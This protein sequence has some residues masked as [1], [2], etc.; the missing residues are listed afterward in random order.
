MGKTIVNVSGRVVVALAA[1]AIVVVEAGIATKMI[2]GRPAFQFQV[3]V[4]AGAIIFIESTI[5]AIQTARRPS[6]DRRT[7]RIEKIVLTALLSVS[8]ITQIPVQKLGG[9]VFVVR[10]PWRS[11]FRLQ[12]I[13]VVRYRLSDFPAPSNLQWTEGVGAIGMAVQQKMAAHA[14]WT[15]F[16]DALNTPGCDPQSI[17]RTV[18]SGQQFGLDDQQLIMMMR[19]YTESFAVPIFNELQ[20]KVVGALALDI[21]YTP[22]RHGIPSV[23]DNPDV[24]RLIATPAAQSIGD[25]VAPK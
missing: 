21:P 7:K 15:E 14:D 4:L 6:I 5:R 1:L 13:R 18:P 23:L 3:L 9:S 25:L 2:S 19:K 8:E 17:C 16:S 22:D 11:F 20:N 12:L 10:R 24:E